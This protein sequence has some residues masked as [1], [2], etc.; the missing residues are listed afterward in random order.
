MLHVQTGDA[1]G[2][3]GARQIGIAAARPAHAMREHDQRH[4]RVFADGRARHR[5]APSVAANAAAPAPRA[6][7]PLSIQSKSTMRMPGSPDCARAVP[8]ALADVSAS[9]SDATPNSRRPA[10]S[11]APP[12]PVCMMILRCVENPTPERA[13]PESAS[14]ESWS[15]ESER[16]EPDSSRRHRSHPRHQSR[17][18]KRL[19]CAGRGNFTFQQ[20]SAPPRVSDVAAIGC[21]RAPSALLFEARARLASRRGEWCAGRRNLPSVCDPFGSPRLP[22]HHHGVFTAAPGRALP[23]CALTCAWRQPAPGRGP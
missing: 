23:P 20:Q 7:A 10:A 1:A 2:R 8:A 13:S 11:D 14:P 16:P 9:A 3:E 22:T 21:G 18:Q 15:G 6:C 5:R 17:S 4:P 12:D 19:K